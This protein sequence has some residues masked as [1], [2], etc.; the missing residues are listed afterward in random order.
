MDWSHEYKRE[1]KVG[2]AD[3]AQ[4]I[5]ASVSMR[6]AIRTYL[7]DAVP[8]GNR[9]PCP[10]HNGKDYNMSFTRSTYHC[11]VCGETGDVIRFTRTLLGLESMMDAIKA[12]NK[13]MGLNLPINGDIDE[14][15]S[16]RCDELALARAA[17]E[18]AHKEWLDTY[19]RLMDEWVEIDK[20]LRTE[21]PLSDKYVDA[22]K[23]KPI[24]EYRLDSL[25]DEPR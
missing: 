7:P 21:E 11:W 23:R 12:L 14:G 17:K 16:R 18:K 15:F 10:F 3:F 5:K 6:D 9:I 22:L 24:V 25:P 13:D 19:H 2:A 8:V 4:S 1:R 20:A